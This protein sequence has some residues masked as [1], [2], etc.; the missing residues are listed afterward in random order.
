MSVRSAIAL[1]VLCLG[2]SAAQAEQSHFGPFVTDTAYPT[3]ILLDGEIEIGSAL[4]FK[5]ALAAAPA[6]TVLALNSPGGDVQIGLLIADNVFEKGLTTF[7]PPGSVCASACSYIFLAGR[8]RTALGR[9]GVHQ[10]HGSVQDNASVQLNMA[11]VFEALNKFGTSPEVINLMLRTPSEDVHFFT[12]D[13]IARFGINRQAPTVVI[14]RTK[15]PFSIDKLLKS[16][17]N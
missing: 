2:S 12:D 9:L 3:S 17:G 5:R 14:K 7:I 6:A 11:D 10:M 16:M 15:G 1:F 4:E 13:E 8:S